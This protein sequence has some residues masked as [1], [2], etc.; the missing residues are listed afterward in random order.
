MQQINLQEQALVG[1]YQNQLAKA[2]EEK[3]EYE[4]KIIQMEAELSRHTSE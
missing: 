3:S 1:E 2:N 4:R